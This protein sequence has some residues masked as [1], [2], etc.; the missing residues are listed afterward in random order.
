MAIGI[1]VIAAG[2]AGLTWWYINTQGERKGPSPRDEDLELAEL[3][4]LARSLKKSKGKKTLK[5]S[6][7]TETE[8]ESE[9][10]V[11]TSARME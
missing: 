3:L 4:K 11:K 5:K 9:A 6:T 10:E 7:A 1:A 2:A 8:E